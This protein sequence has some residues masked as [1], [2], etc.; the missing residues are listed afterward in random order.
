MK[1]LVCYLCGGFAVLNL[2]VIFPALMNGA[3]ANWIGGRVLC[4]LFFGGICYL[5]L[6][7]KNKQSDKPITTV[8]EDKKE[9]NGIKVGENNSKER[10]KD[11]K[12]GSLFSSSATE[13]AAKELFKIASGSTSEIIATSGKLDKK[14][15]CEAIMFNSNIIL[16]DPVLQ[17]KSFYEAISNDYL[18]LLYFLIQ[19]QRGDLKGERLI[20]FISERMEFYSSEYN[21]LRNEKQYSPIWVYST[22]YLAPLEDE[23]KP[24]LD[25]LQVMT[26]QVGLIRM[27]VRVHELL[28]NNL[29][30]LRDD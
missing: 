29:V 23:P 20:N 22:F 7:K 4:V 6:K 5:L 14:G 25:I 9:N 2:L 17:Q 1:K 26:F 3:R 19:Q 21:K 15:L 24:C 16:N 8:Y 10:M 18:M 28:D 12:K 13:G 30:K 11:D 27:A